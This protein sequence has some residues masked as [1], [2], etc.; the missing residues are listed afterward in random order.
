MPAEA[1]VTSIWKKQKLFVAVFLFAFAAYFLWDAVIGYPRM[2]ARYAEWKSYQDSGRLDAWPEYAKQKRWK[3]DEWKKWLDDPHQQGRVPEVRWV[4][5]KIT[6]QYVFAGIGGI[7][8][9][10]AYG[11]WASQK[12]RTVRTDEEAV[13]TP[14]G[15]RVPFDAITGVGKKKWD[16]KGL[17]TVR[18][19][20]EGRKGE[21]VLDDYKFDRDATHQILAE[22]EEKVAGRQ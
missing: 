4:P 5:A 17:A 14:A 15:T 18:Y 13:F 11:F 22:I 9:L 7:L 21:F 6:E 1:R 8:G 3:A 19:E 16:D 10:I 2:N 12:N 20:I